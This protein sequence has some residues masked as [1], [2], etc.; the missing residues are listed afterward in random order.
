MR[1]ITKTTATVVAL[2]TA[3]VLTAAGQEGPGEQIKEGAKETGQAIKE[4]AK[5]VGKEVKSTAKAVG[6]TTKHTAKAIGK[7]TK[8]TAETIGERSRQAWRDTKTYASENRTTYHK[9]AEQRLNDLKSDIAELKGRQS[10]A[11]DPQTFDKQLDTLSAQQASAEEELSRVKEA[12]GTEDYSEAR[13]QFDTTINEMED[14]VVQARK[15]LG[16]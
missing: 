2:W 13:K 11:A 4:T 1:I 12:A 7:E 9:G 15:Q 16:G 10:E 14:G 8:E 5:T 3:A 6:R